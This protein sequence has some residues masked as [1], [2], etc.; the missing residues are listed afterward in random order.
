MSYIS[1]A[2]AL[3]G[4]AFVLALVAIFYIVHTSY[5]ASVDP[6]PPSAQT[7]PESHR[8]LLESERVQTLIKRAQHDPF[9]RHRLSRKREEEL[10]KWKLSRKERTLLLQMSESELEALVH[11]CHSSH[12]AIA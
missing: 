4:G 8:D 5:V 11:S 7:I 12:Q 10:E 3:I 9:F 6:Q 2:F 1:M